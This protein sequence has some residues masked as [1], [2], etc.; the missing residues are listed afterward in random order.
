MCVGRGLKADLYVRSAQR[1]SSKWMYTRKA[2][3]RIGV[4]SQNILIKPA[5]NE[6]T[7]QPPPHSVISR[8]SYEHIY[9]HLLLTQIYMT[10]KWPR[11]HLSQSTSASHRHLVWTAPL[12]D[13]VPV[14][15]EPFYRADVFSHGCEQ[16]NTNL[17][18]EWLGGNE[19]SN[20]FGNTAATPLQHIYR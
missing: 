15:Y 16:L 7:I 1:K 19:T 6:S 11:T 12:V 20:H 10:N 5:Q 18:R 4:F 13:I 14:K 9:I 3:R 17:S 8:I 2:S